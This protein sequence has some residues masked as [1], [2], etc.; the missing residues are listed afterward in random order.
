MKKKPAAPKGRRPKLEPLA[1]FVERG[2]SPTDLASN[3]KSQSLAIRDGRSAD[4]TVHA[5]NDDDDALLLARKQFAAALESN[6]AWSVQAAIDLKWRAGVNGDQSYQWPAVVQQMRDRDQR[7]FETVNLLP[8]SI[9]QVTNQ[10]RQAGLTMNVVPLKGAVSDAAAQAREGLLRHTMLV[11]DGEM[12]IDTA[13]EDMATHGKG[14]VEVVSR[15]EDADDN[16][17]DD[18]ELYIEWRDPFAVLTD[19]A[20]VRLDKSDMKYAFIPFDLPTDDYNALYPESAVATQG[21]L[22]LQGMDPGE[23]ARWFPNGCVRIARYYT[24]EEVAITPAE[25]QRQLTRKSVTLRIVNGLE[26]LETIP[27]SQKASADGTPGR[28]LKRIPIVP[29]LG[30]RFVIDGKEDYRGMVRLARG[31]QRMLNFWITNLEELIASWISSPWVVGWSQVEGFEVFWEANKNTLKYLPYKDKNADGSPANQAPPQRNAEEPPIQATVVAIN[32]AKDALQHVLQIFD[33]SLGKAKSDQ[34]GAAIQSLQQQGEIGTSN[35]LDN[36]KRFLRSLGRLL[37][38]MYPVYYDT[39]RMRRIIGKEAQATSIMVHAGAEN[40][41]SADDL[42]DEQIGIESVFDLAEGQYDITVSTS[43]NFLSKRQEANAGMFNIWKAMPQTLPMMLPEFLDNSDW[44]GARAMAETARRT[45]SAPFQKPDPNDPQQ[46]LGQ[47][48]QTL[49][50]AMQQHQMLVQELNAKNQIIQTDQIKAQS[51]ESQ[52]QAEMASK[53][54][55]AAYQGEVQLAINAAK[56]EQTQN[57]ALL[58]GRLSQLELILG[59]VHDATMA[60]AEREHAVLQGATQHAQTQELTAQ[61]Q[62]DAQALA[63]AKTPANGNGT[64]EIAS[65]PPSADTGASPA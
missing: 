63:A 47:L 2:A 18:Q 28:A 26:F 17:T 64:A 14:Y 37:L 60:H 51:Q 32:I 27:L 56:L 29:M 23:R 52:R 19:P 1:P 13:F 48:K 58:N 10:Q 30:D 6:S 12:Q 9:K 8:A 57:L 33:P 22:A 15:Y 39:A 46:Q 50:Q 54:R 4:E 61:A 16:Q 65:A 43:P 55:I 34:S 35:Y 25:G 53:E 3:L 41:P 40:A 36:L 38:E 49:D 5:S 24:V 62:Q 31:P 42:L 44:P 20:A 59:H 7:P 21:A 45:I 11:S